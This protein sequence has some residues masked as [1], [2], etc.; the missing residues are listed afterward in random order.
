VR[1]AGQGGTESAA[2]ES[3]AIVFLRNANDRFEPLGKLAST[4]RAVADDDCKASCVDWYGNARPL[5]LGGRV[6][7]LMGYE[8]VEGRLDGGAIRETKRVSFSPL[9][10]LARVN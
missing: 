9:A 3:A 8:I 10:S 1:S 6:L 5:F 2:A 7:A 4:A